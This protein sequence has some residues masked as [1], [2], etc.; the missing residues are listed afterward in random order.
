MLNITW[1]VKHLFKT[2]H[3][4]LNLCLEHDRV[5]HQCLKSIKLSQHISLLHN[6][7]PFR[8]CTLYFKACLY[9]LL[10]NGR[11]GRGWGKISKGTHPS[12]VRNCQFSPTIQSHKW[13]GGELLSHKSLQISWTWTFFTGE[14]QHR[15]YCIPNDP[16]KQVWIVV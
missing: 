8:N 5:L 2:S 4:V 16:R 11:Q 12:S 6:S 14:V 10:Q 3:C 15:F 7:T 1:C 13:Q 9:N